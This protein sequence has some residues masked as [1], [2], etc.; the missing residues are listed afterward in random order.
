MTAIYAPDP[1]PVIRPAA[2]G[3]KSFGIHLHW[4]PNDNRY[5]SALPTQLPFGTVRSHDYQGAR[6]FDIETSAGIYNWTA[7]DAWVNALYPAYD[8]VFT[9][10]GTPN[11]YSARASEA[12]SW[13]G[14]LGAS[15][16]PTDLT[17]L[18]NYCVAVATRYLGKIKYYEVW[19]EPAFAQGSYFTG[20][21]AKLAEMTRVVNLAVK[22]VDATAKI[23]SPPPANMTLAKMTPILPADASGITYLGNAGTGTFC[24]DWVDIIGVHGYPNGGGKYTIGNMPLG[25]QLNA[26]LHDQGQ[27]AKEIWC[28]EIGWFNVDSGSDDEALRQEARMLLMAYAAGCSRVFH[29]AYDHSYMG[30]YNRP[31]VA[32]G[33]GAVMAQCQGRTLSGIANAHTYQTP[34]GIRFNF[35]DGSSIVI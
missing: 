1:Y 9:V 32:G 20:T 30:I 26:Y 12:S 15:A 27:S 33:I 6:W 3:A 18:G 25:L 7:L 5:I 35:T 2:I 31:A 24:K 4:F 11:F 21:A 22:S 19:N 28:T 8:L 10:I 14:H 16:E 34:D 29:Y 23:I 17:N 13:G